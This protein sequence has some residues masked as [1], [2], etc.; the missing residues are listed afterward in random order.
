[1]DHFTFFRLEIMS[2]E[3]H[4]MYQVS[5][6][7]FHKQADQNGDKELLKLKLQKLERDERIFQKTGHTDEFGRLIS[8]EHAAQEKPK[9]MVDR[10]R[11][12]LDKKQSDRGQKTGHEV[13]KVKNK[14]SILRQSNAPL[15]LNPFQAAQDRM[16]IQD[17][18]KEKLERARRKD[19]YM[20]GRQKGRWER[21]EITALDLGLAEKEYREAGTS[22][23]N[24]A[25]K[26]ESA[27][28]RKRKIAAIESEGFNPIQTF[29]SQRKRPKPNPKPSLTIK[30]DSHF[31]AI[32]APPSL[33]EPSPSPSADPVKE[34]PVAQTSFAEQPS[35]I[36]N[37]DYVRKPKKG[38][39]RE[40]MRQRKQKG[41]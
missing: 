30:D 28:Q 41:K 9:T 40:C 38:G 19:S 33:T 25:V 12:K 36:L 14:S 31:H 24:I 1:V 2:R 8:R 11:K 4:E 32:F 15:P 39:W 5:D 34:N 20:R 37:Q 10:I 16:K 26:L 6:G 23:S 22:A 7:R 17:R 35:S 29:E 13:F 3:L 21:K 27:A 18:L